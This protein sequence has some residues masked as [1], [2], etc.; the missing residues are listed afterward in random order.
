LQNDEVI[1]TKRF[2]RSCR[3]G[4]RKEEGFRDPGKPLPDNCLCG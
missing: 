2:S 1:T 3:S 4:G